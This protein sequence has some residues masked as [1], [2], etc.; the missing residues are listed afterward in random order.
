M[1]KLFPWR[2]SGLALAAA[3]LAA[4]A[5]AHDGV[6][7]DRAKPGAANAAAGLVAPL[8]IRL[9][10][11][12]VTDQHGVQHRLASALAPNR[13][14]VVNF[15]FTSCT[16]VCSPMTAIVKSARQA[17]GPTAR[18]EVHFVSVSVDPLNDTPQRLAEYARKMQADT[19]NW[20]FVTGSRRDIDAILRAF[21][22]PL[23][24]NLDQHT[25]MVYIGQPGARHWTR[26]YG[27]APPQT[28]AE[29]I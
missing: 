7:H 26:A 25:P 29:R 24:G 17:L 22:V 3:A 10:D 16:S 1:Q 13:T 21:G 28:L 4:S 23:G 11:V 14:L 15:V 8:D 18:G 5:A 19:P 27:L 2:R 20:S 9:P 6:D 12:T